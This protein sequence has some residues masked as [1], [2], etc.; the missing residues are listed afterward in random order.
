MDKV[1]YKLNLKQDVNLN[2]VLNYYKV[3]INI[4]PELKEDP[5]FNH[6]LNLLV[7]MI[8]NVGGSAKVTTVGTLSNEYI[9][10]LYEEDMI[11]YANYFLDDAVQWSWE[12]C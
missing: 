6:H 3:S 7:A 10:P 2:D 12:N 4:Y 9:E 5:M 1:N 8:A 11:L